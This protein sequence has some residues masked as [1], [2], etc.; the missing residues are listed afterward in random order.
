MVL[1][2]LSWCKDLKRKHFTCR[3]FFLY[4][5]LLFP[6]FLH[7]FFRPEWL[8]FGQKNEL[9]VFWNAVKETRV[10]NFRHK[11]FGVLPVHLQRDNR[12]KTCLLKVV[13]MFILRI[14]TF[15]MTVC[16]NIRLCTNMYTLHKENKLQF[17]SQIISMHMLFLGPPGMAPLE[18]R[19]GP[20]VG[21]SWCWGWNA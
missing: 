16:A 2:W 3:C 12:I 11:H 13:V 6:C 8:A 18:Q 20:A 10:L 9:Y 7:V 4:F 19:E 15:L 5:T 1:D 21:A 17:Y 14:I